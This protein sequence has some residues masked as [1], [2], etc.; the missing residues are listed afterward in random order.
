MG[1][2]IVIHLQKSSCPK[3]LT[4]TVQDTLTAEF[5]ASGYKKSVWNKTYIKN[6]LLAESY[7]KCAYCEAPI[8]AGHREIHVDH[9]MPKSKYPETVVQWDNLIPS[10]PHCN[11]SK[12]D[13][14]PSEYPIVNPY[15]DEPKEF[16]ILKIIDYDVKKEVTITRL[17]IQ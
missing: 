13:I 14:D 17:K 6:A 16:F 5:I 1:G 7:S 2:L 9:F 3:Q 10:C 15:K 12:S 11:K 4:A 8:G